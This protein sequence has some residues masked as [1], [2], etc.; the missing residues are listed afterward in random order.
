LLVPEEGKLLATTASSGGIGSLWVITIL[1]EGPPRLIRQAAGWPAISPDGRL[2]AF[3]DESRGRDE[4]EIWV[5]GING[6]GAQKL[7]PWEAR[8]RVSGAVWSPDGTWIAYLKLPELHRV[9]LLNGGQAPGS[10]SLSTMEVRPSGGGPARG[11]LSE[12]TLPAPNALNCWGERCLAWLPDWRLVFLVTEG[13]AVRSIG[14]KGSLWSIRMKLGAARVGDPQ[15]LSGPYADF[16]PANLTA[17][18]DGRR[19]AFQKIRDQ[20]DVDV[21]ELGRDDNTLIAARPPRCGYA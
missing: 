17:S 14:G 15:P 2:M 9:G 13:P 18:A 21:G 3:V 12:P 8:Y 1:G 19:L 7:V 10:P 6:D 16:V 5:S 4:T 20:N 11:V